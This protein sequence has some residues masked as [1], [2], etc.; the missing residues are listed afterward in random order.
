MRSAT[1]RNN[2]ATHQVYSFSLFLFLP[3]PLPLP[4]HSNCTG[5][6]KRKKKPA[7]FTRPLLSA[8]FSPFFFTSFFKNFYL[9]VITVNL[10]HIH[11]QLILLI[12]NNIPV[13]ST[14]TPS[15]L[16]LGIYNN[17]TIQKGES[18]KIKAII[19]FQLFSGQ[20]LS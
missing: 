13:L 14:H 5:T 10:F 2:C 6:K 4:F 7:I 11:L 15:G 18:K 9:V 19:T 8:F 16:F 3:L 20:I 17:I 12:A 1:T